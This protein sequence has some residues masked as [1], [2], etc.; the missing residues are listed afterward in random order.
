MVVGFIEW[1]FIANYLG[2]FLYF[3]YNTVAF[4]NYGL[5]III[6]T[7]VIK[8][9][10]MPLTFKQLRSSAKM[11]EIQPKIQEI[12]KMYKNDKEKLNKELMKFYQ[13]NKVNPAAGCLPLLIQ[14][15]ILFSLY[16]AIARPL[17]YM[18]GKSKA[19]ITELTSIT[20][21]LAK[22][23]DGYNF[24]PKGTDVQ[25][26]ILNF[27][28]E[29]RDKL[30]QVGKFLKE[31]ELL[32]MF[33]PTNGFGVNLSSKPTLSISSVNDLALLIIPL[34]AVL[35]TYL[36]TRLSMPKPSKDNKNAQMMGFMVYF[37][38]LMTLVIGFQFPIGL[39]LYW[40][41]SSIFQIGQQLVI[42]KYKLREVGKK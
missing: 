26:Q 15:P 10:L 20:K 36:S 3:I 23:I 31:N 41:T 42:N 12:Q 37:A 38:P 11:Q 21:D 35:F 2:Q 4:E 39:A 29:H 40:T 33:F 9:A 6:F 32:N 16:W 1:G 8:L 30:S 17:S 27:Y 19:Q 5:A 25:I 14:M 7:I 22:S 28:G 18:L 34:L 13:E 24:N